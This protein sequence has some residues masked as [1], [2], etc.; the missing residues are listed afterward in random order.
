M[1]DDELPHPPPIRTSRAGALPADAD[2]TIAAH[3]HVGPPG[4]VLSGAELYESPKPATQA[5]QRFTTAAGS[6][7][8][9]KS[10]GASLSSSGV[11]GALPQ[12]A[13]VKQPIVWGKRTPLRKDASWFALSVLLW[14]VA[15]VAYYLY[16]RIAFTLDLQRGRWYSIIVLVVEC[17]GISAVLPYGARAR[18]SATQACGLR[19]GQ[20][21]RHHTRCV[22][23]VTTT[24]RLAAAAT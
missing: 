4:F 17:I 21:Q 24:A 10:A 5:Y 22:P 13:T 3:R 2:F 1:A 9:S 14:Y 12:S 8:G 11:T 15:S 19:E 6:S 7:P 16:V 23:P 18:G 20:Q